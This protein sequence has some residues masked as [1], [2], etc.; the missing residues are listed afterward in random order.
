M[1]VSRKGEALYRAKRRALTVVLSL[2]VAM[3][4][5]GRANADIVR[6]LAFV[7]AGGLL[8]RMLAALVPIVQGDLTV[9]VA[10]AHIFISHPLRDIYSIAAPPLGKPV[11]YPPGY[12]LIFRAIG[13]LDAFLAS[14]AAAKEGDT[15][16]FVLKIPAILADL[17]VCSVVFVTAR[18]WVPSRVAIVAAAVA[19]LMPTSWPVSAVWGQVDSLCSVFLILAF[20]FSLRGAYTAS[21]VALAAGILIKPFPIFAIPVLVVQMLRSRSISWKMAIGPILAVVVAYAVASPFAPAPDPRTVFLW[22]VNE[23]ALGQDLYATTSANATNV[24]LLFH[25]EISDRLIVAG[26]RLQAWG[27]IAFG[28]GFAA[29]LLAMWRRLGSEPSA[30]RREKIICLTW[31]LTFASM[32]MLL[33]RMHERYIIFAMVF[34]PLLWVMGRVERNVVISLTCTFSLVL[35]LILVLPTF[36]VKGLRQIMSIGNVAAM[37]VLVYGFAKGALP[38]ATALSVPKSG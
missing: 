25:G 9:F 22:L 38:S 7:L 16:R 35:I 19:A 29:L 10:W 28:T 32:F 1:A 11:N 6:L 34:S 33:T 24:W 15:I 23:Y 8:V 2:E 3:E 17:V 12:V 36:H 13:E 21:W 5:I 4:R 30:V 14:H 31:F 18:R 37:A 26:L 27:W 20:Y